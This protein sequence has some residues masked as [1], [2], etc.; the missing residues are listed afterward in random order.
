MAGPEHTY[1]VNQAL[2]PLQEF[3]DALLG[4]SY[5]SV[6]YVKP[7]LHLMKT[8]VLAEKEENSGLTVHQ[9]EN[10]GLLEH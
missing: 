6:S 10:L 7:V 2:Q 9:D 1:S 3:T 5:V 4:E 8:L